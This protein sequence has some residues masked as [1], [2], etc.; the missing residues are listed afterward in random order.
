MV[1]DQ[2]FQGHGRVL[3]SKPV[4]DKGRTHAGRSQVLPVPFRRVCRRLLDSISVGAV[5]C[6]DKGHNQGRLGLSRNYDWSMA[7]WAKEPLSRRIK[8]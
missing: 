8:H 5:E 2:R 1:D 6:G 7:A 4:G 3:Q